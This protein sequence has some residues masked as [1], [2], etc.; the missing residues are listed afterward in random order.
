MA[1]TKDVTRHDALL[2]IRPAAVTFWLLD[3][4]ASGM[5]TAVCRVAGVAEHVLLAIFF[6]PA[7]SRD[8]SR[9]AA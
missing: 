2:L 3:W 1:A 5:A 7:W 8:H 6:I 4:E 9:I